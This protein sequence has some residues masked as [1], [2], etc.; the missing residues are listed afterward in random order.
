MGHHLTEPLHWQKHRIHQPLLCRFVEVQR[1]VKPHS[2]Q[3]DDL[4]TESRVWS[5]ATP[6]YQTVDK[7]IKLF[8]NPFSCDRD[9]IIYILTL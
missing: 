1:A 7:I 6:M 8:R 5:D 4:H 3:N 2:L 9:R